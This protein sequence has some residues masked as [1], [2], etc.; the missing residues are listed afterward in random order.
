MFSFFLC[1]Y[2]YSFGV[3]SRRVFADFKAE[4]LTVESNLAWRRFTLAA[5]RRTWKKGKEPVASPL[6]RYSAWLWAECLVGSHRTGVG[7][8]LA[9]SWRR[10]LGQGTGWEWPP[11]LWLWVGPEGLVVLPTVTMAETL[12]P[13]ALAPTFLKCKKNQYEKRW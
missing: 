6:T 8:C 5:R 7:P 9:R 2:R 1:L 11:S 13:V 3:G 12:S 10:T 4:I